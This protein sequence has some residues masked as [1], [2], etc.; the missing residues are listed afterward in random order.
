MANFQIAYDKTNKIEGG[1]ANNP[2]DKGGETWTGIARNKWPDWD[3]WLIVDEL[4]R[5]TGFPAIL[6][7]HEGL[8]QK[9]L[10]FYKKNFWDAL[11]L[12]SVADQNVANELYDSG[13]NLG[14]GVAGTYL[15][16]VLNVA[17]RN[18]LYYPDLLV[19]GQVGT[20]TIKALNTHPK[21]YIILRAL[22][23]LQGSKYIGICESNPSQEEFFNG[24][25]ERV[26]EY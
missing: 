5:Q 24:W 17:N 20:K 16:R 13:V 21:P 23:C 3:G 18:G 9:K 19:D 1:Y 2:K 15:Q 14:T 4:K 7:T 11:L 25:M 6:A 22:N 26:L 8:K 10:S 12:D